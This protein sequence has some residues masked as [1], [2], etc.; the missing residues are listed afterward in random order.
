[1]KRFSSA[2]GLALASSAGPGRVGLMTALCVT[3]LTAGAISAKDIA[4]PD[5]PGPFHVG[6]TTFPAVMSGGRVAQIR[7]WYPT[8]EAA[9]AQTKYTI[10]RAG[11]SYQLKSPFWAVDGATALPGSFPLVVHDH[12][13][14]TVGTDPRSVANLPL[15]ETM[16]S[17]GFVVAVALHSANAVARVRDLSLVIDILL[18]RSASAGDL[19]AGSIDPGRI[20]ISGHS[21]GGGAALGTAGGWAVNG[22]AADR[23]IKAAVVYEPSV[24]SLDDASTLD[25]PYL[26]MGGAQSQLGLAVP[27]L[28]DATV[29]ATP[30]IW[31]LSPNAT[32]LNYTTGAGPEIDQAR[33]QALLA[34]P[35]IPEPLTTLTASSAAAAQ[36]YELW[37]FGE[38][39]FPLN[40]FGRGGGRNFCNRVGVNSVR[41]LDTHPRDGF[42]DS[43][44]FMASDA[45]TLKPATPEEVMVPLIE[46][47]TVAFWKTFLEGDHRYQR[48]LAPGYAQR[49]G[50]E[51]IV[52]IV[53]D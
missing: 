28:F 35:N 50:L 44:P 13:G 3:F 19:L 30:R 15:H 45:F 52:T 8:L 34:N 12:G 46:L 43:P 48:Y 36:A 1:M 14:P 26:V 51:A 22:I 4:P 6:V 16:A 40:G 18:D 20:G 53:G 7:V 33:E 24:I 2:A 17:H 11:G 5:Q 21:T 9:G 42:T 31:V 49:H 41:S 39:Q 10:F 25:I 38:T 23:R 47:Y 27:T 37:N 29:L 32:H